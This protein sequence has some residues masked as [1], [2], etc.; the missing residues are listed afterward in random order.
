M[1]KL[2][3]RTDVH[4]SDHTPKRRNGNWTDDVAKKLEWIGAYTQE[5]KIDAVIDGGDFFDVKT[6][7]RNSHGLVS[8]TAK[9]HKEYA[10]SVYTLVG[11]HDVKYGNIDYLEEQP[12]AVLFNAGVFEQFG[13]S[14]EVL[15]EK[16]G[17]RVRLVGIP[18]HGTSYDWDLIRSIKK[19][20]E[21]YLLVACHLLASEKGGVGAM[22]EG[23]DI[24]PY[25]EL[26]GRGVDGW[27]FGHWH[28]DQGIVQWVDTTVVNVGS[29]TR[30]SL[31][32]DDLDR[33]PYMVVVSIDKE[34]IEF[35]KVDVPCREDAFKVEEAIIEKNNKKRMEEIVEKMK[36]VATEDKGLSLIDRVNAIV[37][38]DQKVKE[39]AISYLE[40]V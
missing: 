21:D 22:F 5:H 24:V 6:P 19:G 33:K 31:H 15:F 28:K 14:K 8:R 18:Y 20:D 23:E 10:C 35:L 38:V 7:S 32:L 27:F 17:L 29:L 1:I 16:D 39:I 40:K 9:I 4:F 34:G 37:G 11:N 3:W 26:T 2:I 12:L 13:G 30:G 36:R 25:D